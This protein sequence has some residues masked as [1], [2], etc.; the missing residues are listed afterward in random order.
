MV[1]NREKI[2][3]HKGENSIGCSALFDTGAGRSYLNEEIAMKIGYEHYPEPRKID[4]AVK[5]KQAEVIG[6][7]AVDIE[8][9]GYVLPEKEILGVVK[10]LNVEAIIGLNIM[11]AYGIV[12]EEGRVRLT[13]KPP[14]SFLF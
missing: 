7:T 1:K 5:G 8:I 12:L 10:E 4:L 11:E 3:I 9:S 2:K 6:Y 13:R 14:S